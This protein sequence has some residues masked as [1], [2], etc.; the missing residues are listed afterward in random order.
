MAEDKELK[1]SLALVLDK[2]QKGLKKGAGL[3]GQFASEVDKKISGNKFLAP[4]VKGLGLVASVL[5]TVIGAIAAVV[6]ALFS[7]FTFALSIVGKVVSLVWTL[8]KAIFA[9]LKWAVVTVWN[10]FGKLL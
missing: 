10:L 2:F 6:S 4:L 9:A 5:S 3:L 7:A 1:V 8:A